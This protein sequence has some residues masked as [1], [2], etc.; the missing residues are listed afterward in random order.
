MSLLQHTL[1]NGATTKTLAEWGIVSCVVKHQLGGDDTLDFTVSGE[2]DQQLFPA[3]AA[4]VLKDWLG[5]VRFSGVLTKSSRTAKGSSQERTYSCEGPSYYL[6]RAYYRQ[7]WYFLTEPSDFDDVAALVEALKSD[8]DSLL[9][10]FGLEWTGQVILGRT[11]AGASVNLQA[12]VKAALD[13]TI[14]E[15][16]APIAYNLGALPALQLPWAQQNDIRVLDVIRNQL[17]WVPHF[18]WR[19]QYPSDGTQPFALFANTTAGDGFIVEGQ[20]S[21]VRTLDL[22]GENP[23]AVDFM[24]D[25][26]W[27]LLSP[28]VEL[29]YIYGTNTVDVDDETTYARVRLIH[30]DTSTFVANGAFGIDRATIELQGDIVNYVGGQRYTTSGQVV[31][32]DG[33]AQAMHTAYARPYFD[34]RFSTKNVEV[35]WSCAVG[36]RFNVIGALASYATCEAIV[37]TITRD[38]GAGTTS[39]ECGP[40]SQ[41][42]FSDRFAMLQAARLRKI[43]QDTGGQQ[44]G[45]TKPSDNQPPPSGGATGALDFVTVTLCGDDGTPRTLAVAIRKDT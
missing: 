26:R 3:F 9:S 21:A 36:E 39:W 28:Q 11:N 32:A 17:R 37:Q 22:R 2:I 6:R 20:V 19:W 38:I 41:L 18:N 16:G 14:A 40:P 12:Q 34:L 1:T 25:A 5:L 23:L 27:D 33:L 43:G 15:E 30:R 35:D 4:I 42:G 13:Y 10:H 8:P 45:L 29:T 7:Q 24:G 44:N 31:P